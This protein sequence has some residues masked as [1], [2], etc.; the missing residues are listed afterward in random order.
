MIRRIA[1][2]LPTRES[3]Q[4]NRWLRWMG[5]A[6]AHPR[7]WHM[8]RKGIAAGLAL[9]LFFGLLVP[10]AQI[11]LAATAAVVLRANLPV[12]IG[13]TLVTNPVTFGPVYYGAYKLGDWLLH[14][15][16]GPVRSPDVLEA[17]LQQLHEA[18][19]PIVE[20][21]GVGGHIRAIWTRITALGKPLIL[22]LVILATATGVG[23]Y[24][25]TTWVWAA[26]IWLK[27]RRRLVR[28]REPVK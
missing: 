23:V 8:S 6:L 1:Q 4:A 24:L 16:D 22:G 17:R 10:I 19:A 11:P 18:P 5:P 14:R 12:A 2:S 27:R 13:S 3:I 9:G 7:L 21:N 26:M 15:G 25:L 28:R 20:A